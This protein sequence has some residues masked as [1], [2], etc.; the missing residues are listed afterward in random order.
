[1]HCQYFK[2]VVGIPVEVVVGIPVVVSENLLTRATCNVAS[3]WVIEHRRNGNK[4]K[5]KRVLKRLVLTYSRYS[6]F[7]SVCYWQLSKYSKN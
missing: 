6:G 2:N 4:R 3:E 5:I 1:M 7:S